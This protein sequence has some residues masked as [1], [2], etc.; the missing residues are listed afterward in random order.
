[1]GNFSILDINTNNINNDTNISKM[2]NISNH[3]EAEV[4]DYYYF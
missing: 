3:S 4:K 1:V 2:H